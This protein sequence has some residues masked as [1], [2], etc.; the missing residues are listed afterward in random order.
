MVVFSSCNDPGQAIELAEWYDLEHMNDVTDHSGF[1]NATRFE[2]ATSLTRDLGPGYLAVYEYD[3]GDLLGEYRRLQQFMDDIPFHPALSID[4][5]GVLERVGFGREA[6]RSMDLPGL[7]VGCTDCNDPEQD[8][9]FN[10]WYDSVHAPDP[11][12]SGIYQS[13]ARYRRVSGNLPFSYLALYESTT[14]EPMASGAFMEWP[15]RN[16]ELHPALEIRH[17]WAYNKIFS[18]V[19]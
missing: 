11:V 4:S 16:P 8:Q 13:A 12:N 2:L 1:A 3:G 19:S 17:V 7:L 6:R 18:Q 9:E 15:G 5:S 10:D 14:M